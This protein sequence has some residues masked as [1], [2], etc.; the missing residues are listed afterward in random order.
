MNAALLQA[1]F[2]TQQYGNTR[3]TKPYK[4]NVEVPTNYYMKTTCCEN[5]SPYEMVCYCNVQ[6]ATT[7]CRVY[8]SYY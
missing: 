2:Q 5:T 8:G 7:T 3:I 4:P 1:L 6:P